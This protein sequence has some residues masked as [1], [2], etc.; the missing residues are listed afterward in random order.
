MANLFTEPGLADHQILGNIMSSI[1]WWELSPTGLNGMGTIVTSGAGTQTTFTDG[2]VPNGTGDW[3]VSAAAPDGSVVIAYVPNAHSGAF[4]V[5][6]TKLSGTSSASWLDP[7]NGSSQSAGS[8]LPNSGTHSFTVPGSNSGGDND[9]V[10]LIR[11]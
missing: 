1:P 3:I 6:M 10:L 9:W 4:S 5:D 7:V 2:T 11:V 8:S